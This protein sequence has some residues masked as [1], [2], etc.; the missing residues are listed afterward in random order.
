[1]TEYQKRLKGILATLNQIEI[2][3]AEKS[4][5]ID[6][7]SKAKDDESL[8]KAIN[9]AEKFL[10][11]LKETTDNEARKKSEEITR[12]EREPEHLGRHTK[13]TLEQELFSLQN[14]KP[15]FRNRKWIK[16]FETV[17]QAID[18][19]KDEELKKNL[20]SRAQSIWAGEI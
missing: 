16:R 5:L 7:V 14:T 2:P 17:T 12:G 11:D 8:D 4:R 13:E 19:M 15:A 6:I 18:T 9:E 10:Q 20:R 1:M 3:K